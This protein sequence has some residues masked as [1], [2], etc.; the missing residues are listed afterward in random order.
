MQAQE[1]NMKC[2]PVH[3]S[4]RFLSRWHWHSGTIHEVISTLAFNAV[5]PMEKFWTNR[6]TTGF[7]KQ[8]SCHAWSFEIFQCR[9]G[10]ELRFRFCVTSRHGALETKSRR[11][12]AAQT[13]NELQRTLVAPQVL[14]EAFPKKK[15]RVQLSSD[16]GWS[17][18]APNPVRPLLRSARDVVLSVPCRRLCAVQ[19]QNTQRLRRA[20]SVQYHWRLVCCGISWRQWRRTVGPVRTWFFCQRSREYR[21][22]GI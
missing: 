5:K 4:F 20:R 15:Q 14:L 6:V 7:A 21:P 9:S 10:S 1:K 2:L 12:T 17:H 13:P 11:R 8:G 3:T 19:R 16:A 22:R 18:G